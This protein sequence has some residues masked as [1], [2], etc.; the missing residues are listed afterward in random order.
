MTRRDPRNRGRRYDGAVGER[1]FARWIIR[2]IRAL[3]VPTV[4]LS[5]LLAVDVVLP[6]TAEQ[7]LVYRRAVDSHWVGPDGVAVSVGWPNR[8]NCLEQRADSGKKLLFTTRPGCATT[9]SVSPSF[10][11]RVAGNDTLRVVRTPLFRQVRAVQRTDERTVDWYPLWDLGFYVV[12]GLVPL[13]S[14]GQ[15]FGV[16]ETTGGVARYHVAY[17]LPAAA[18]EALYA[19][20]VVE[21]VRRAGLL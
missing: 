20:L 15:D 4:G 17:L 5:L 1:W 18:A 6:G 10:G 14:F 13:L 21:A 3:A 12:V 2:A 9:L 16:Y 7:G 8:P 19:W 11:R